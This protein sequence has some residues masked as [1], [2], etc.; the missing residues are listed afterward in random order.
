MDREAGT[1]ASSPVSPHPWEF[2]ANFCE[3]VKPT[4]AKFRRSARLCC[5]RLRYV[6]FRGYAP[7][8]LP[9]LVNIMWHH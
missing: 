6:Y 3:I 4:T 2:A 7:I 5:K 9:P 8:L 1:R